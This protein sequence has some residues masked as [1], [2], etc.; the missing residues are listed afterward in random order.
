MIPPNSIINGDCF[1]VMYEIDDASVD[2]IMIDPPYNQTSNEWDVP[3]S[4]NELWRHYH[5]ILKENGTIA[6]MAKGRFYIKLVS[7]NID[8]YRYEWVWNKKKGANFCHV[9]RMPLYSHELVVIF[10]RKVGTYNPQMTK[11]NGKIPRFKHRDAEE[12]KGVADT[13]NRTSSTTGGPQYPKT[14]L[15]NIPG[16][17]QMQIIH[18]TQKPVALFEYFIK[19]YTNKGDLVL[20]SFAGVMTCAIACKATGRN[21]IC[22]EKEKEYCAK[23]I[24]LL[25]D[26]DAVKHLQNR[27]KPMF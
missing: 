7:S 16:I 20:D 25:H 3:F 2:F 24:D 15:D 13:T 27:A 21:Y 19:T 17:A 6:I 14:V 10:Y 1:D 23:G 11:I 12:I 5:R 18:P 22:I 9:A 8:E 4:L 26:H